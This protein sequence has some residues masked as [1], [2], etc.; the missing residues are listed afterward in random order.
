MAVALPA[1]H[2]GH[3]R[4]SERRRLQPSW[5]L[6]LGA[7]QRLQLR[8]WVRQHLSLDVADVPLFGLV[9][10]VGRRRRRRDTDMPSQGRAGSN[11][12]ADCPPSGHASLRC[13]N[14]AQYA[15]SCARRPARAVPSHRHCCDR[16]R[17]APVCRLPVYGGP[18]LSGHASLRGDG[19]LRT[20]YLQRLPAGMERAAGRPTLCQDGTPRRRLPMVEAVT[21]ADPKT[22][23][24]VP[25][26]G[27]SVGE[28]MVRSNTVM[29]GYLKN[30]AATA[31]TLVGSW[32]LSGDLAVWHPDGAIEIKDRSKDIIISGGENIS[33]LEVEEVLTQHPA[34]MLA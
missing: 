25:R 19:N 14:R 34:V 18:R 17:G 16:R 28:F 10:S 26:D 29:K 6:S 33:S 9:L 3:H 22:M 31:K 15:G 13:A 21:V 27:T 4:R 20:R 8:T 23:H 11:L 1:L 12:P 7:W 5:R 30:E 2:F 32:C 24:P